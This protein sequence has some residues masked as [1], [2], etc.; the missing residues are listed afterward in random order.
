MSHGYQGWDPR[1]SEAVFGNGCRGKA[2]YRSKRQAN[3]RIRVLERDGK[4]EPATMNAYKCKACRT[5]HIGH[6]PGTRYVLMQR[7]FDAADAAAKDEE[8]KN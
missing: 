3:G 8:R 2:H 6:R 7:Q 4:T 1:L 5:W